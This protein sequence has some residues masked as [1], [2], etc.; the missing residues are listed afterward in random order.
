MA[1][2]PPIGPSKT[3]S[4]LE[5]VPRCELSTT[6]ADDIA[7]GAG[8]S[9]SIFQYKINTLRQLTVSTRWV[10]TNLSTRKVSIM[11]SDTPPVTS[12]A[13]QQLN[14]R[15]QVTSETPKEGKVCFLAGRFTTSA[16]LRVSS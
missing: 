3:C 12:R 16:I 2:Q 11:T 15:E 9:E 4:G 6:L 13:I 1:L 7:I 10:S 5:P 14:Q 8:I